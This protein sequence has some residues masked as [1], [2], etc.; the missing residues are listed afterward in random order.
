MI[1]GAQFASQ[2]GD[3]AF[4]AKCQ[5][6]ADNI[7]QTLRSHYNG[8]F[9][10]ESANRLRDA[11]VI[12]AFNEGYSGGDFGPTSVEVANTIKVYNQLFCMTYAINQQ[13]TREHIPGVLYGR[14]ENDHFAG[15]NPWIL[16]SA[17]LAELFYR[18]AST[19]LEAQ[20]VPEPEAL[21]V[22]KYILNVPETATLTHFRFAE[23]MASA[24]DSVLQRIAYHVAGGG[25][26]LSEQ[27][28]RNTGYEKSATDLTWSYANV[29]KAMYVR[30]QVMSLLHK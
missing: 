28:D 29:L 27:L 14:Y 6:V 30:D 5:Q 25:F 23:L 9:V 1:L 26:H 11:A 15:G 3:Q 12:S 10:F 22:W 8:Q 7:G 20:A 19:T 18:G 17:S 24:G 16:T 2:M 4:S 13:D 21:K